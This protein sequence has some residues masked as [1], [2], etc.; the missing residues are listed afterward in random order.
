MDGLSAFDDALTGRLTH[1][2]ACGAWEDPD[3][4]IG[5][6]MPLEGLQIEVFVVLC[7]RCARH[8]EQLEG[9]VLAMLGKRYARKEGA[10]IGISS[11]RL[12]NL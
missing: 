11:R 12:L 4:I 8:W 10:C 7:G 5:Q 1:C 6:L 9:R 2:T 3:V